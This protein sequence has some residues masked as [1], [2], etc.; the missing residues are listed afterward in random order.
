MIASVWLYR[1]FQKD[2]VYVPKCQKIVTWHLVIPPPGE[3]D[4]KFNVGA[5][6]HSF[7]YE[8]P[9]N[10]GLQVYALYRF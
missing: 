3:I 10:I 4:E 5:Q 6:L 1:V 8:M 7:W 9:L 2:T